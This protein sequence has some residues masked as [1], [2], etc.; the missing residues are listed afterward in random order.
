MSVTIELSP[1]IEAGLAAQADAQGLPLSEYLRHLLEEQVSL[2]T[3]SVLSPAQRAA[4]WRESAK[5]LPHTPPLADEAIGRDSI[6]D[7]RG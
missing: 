3:G 1:E 7:A 2:G 4:A 6:Y 5:D